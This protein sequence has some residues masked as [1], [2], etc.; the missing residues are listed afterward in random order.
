MRA[1]F[2]LH[3]HH[4]LLLGLILPWLETKFDLI[5]EQ[6]LVGVDVQSP[7]GRQVDYTERK[8]SCQI[9]DHR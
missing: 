7:S 9:R 5:V 6:R 8:W 3:K 1:L 2:D 4:S